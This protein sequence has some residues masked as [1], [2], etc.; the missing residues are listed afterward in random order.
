M[1]RFALYELLL[2]GP[3]EPQEPL[4]RFDVSETPVPVNEKLMDRINNYFV[5][6]T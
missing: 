5:L 1:N 6:Q 2:S 3:V 4:Y